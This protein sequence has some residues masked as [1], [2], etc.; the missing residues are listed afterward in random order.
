MLTL[1]LYTAPPPLPAAATYIA[2]KMP[3]GYRFRLTLFWEVV[4]ISDNVFGEVV[5]YSTVKNIYNVAGKK[6]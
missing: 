2:R 3:N 1:V 4:G 6:F 5:Y